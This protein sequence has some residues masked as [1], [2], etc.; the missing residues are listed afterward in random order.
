VPRPK[1]RTPELRDRVLG[2]AVDVL[3]REGVSGF[4]T[5]GVARAASTSPPAVYELFGDKGGLVRAVFFEGFRR[6]RVELDAVGESDD[7]VAD[8]IELVGMYR[9]FLSANPVLADV[10]FSRPFTDFQASPEDIARSGSVREFIVGR[11][12]R[13]VDTGAL[14]GDPTDIAHALV[15]LVQGLSAAENSR[16]LGTSRE[17]VDRRWDAAVR[18][19]LDGFRS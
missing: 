6:L 1:Q 9:G 14:A 19:L 8:V 5:R 7:P 18:A 3:A 17:S 16:R 4:T 10:M 15:A 13:C 11:I 12:H 2:V